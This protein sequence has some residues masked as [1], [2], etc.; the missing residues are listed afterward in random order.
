MRSEVKVKANNNNNQI[1]YNKAVGKTIRI[2]DSIVG[3]A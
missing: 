3:D 2:N 1:Y